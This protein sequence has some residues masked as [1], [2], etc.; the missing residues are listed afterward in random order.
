MI[1]SQC[2]KNQGEITKINAN[3]E[4]IISEYKFDDFLN[5][6]IKIVNIDKINND[7]PEGFIRNTNP[8]NIPKSTEKILN[9]RFEI[10]HLVSTRN[11]KEE[12]AVKD[13]SI[14]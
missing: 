14:R 9:F 3:S 11:D 5:L 4:R 6:S 2:L 8:R 1:V 13:R 10:Y 12:K 7:T